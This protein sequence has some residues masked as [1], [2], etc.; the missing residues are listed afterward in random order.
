MEI[1]IDSKRLTCSDYLMRKILR[2]SYKKIKH[3]V[4]FFILIEVLMAS[5]E[6]LLDVNFS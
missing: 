6:I 3:L 4:K 2:I 5:I 1:I